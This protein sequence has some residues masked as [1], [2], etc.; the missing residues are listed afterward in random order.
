MSY[1]TK[2]EYLIKPT[3]S[4]RILKNCQGCGCKSSFVSTSSFRVNANGNRVDVW[5]IYQCEK[6]KHTYNLTIHERIKPSEL[7]T[8][9][10]SR[11]LSNDD[12]LAMK[13]GMDKNLLSKNKVEIDWENLS[14]ELYPILK[15]RQ[16]SSCIAIQNPYDIKVRMDKILSEILEISRSRVKELIKQELLELSTDKVTHTVTVMIK[17]AMTSEEKNLQ[18]G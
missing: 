13:H 3:E 2:N 6:C 9:E 12:E 16:Q 4:Y 8:E 10:Y 7:S 5:L 17:S 14:F 11:Y 18:V 1:R 15:S